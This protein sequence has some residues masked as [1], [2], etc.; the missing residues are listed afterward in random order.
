MEAKFPNSEEPEEYPSEEE[1]EE[2]R[3][4]KD[5]EFAEWFGDLAH[6]GL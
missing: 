3:D 2:M 4:A 6:D 1:L 5:R